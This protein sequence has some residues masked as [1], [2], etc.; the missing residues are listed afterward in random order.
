L[1]SIV[2]PS[3]PTGAF[4][5]TGY[6]AAD[7]GVE[8]LLTYFN[9]RVPRPGK[10]GGTLIFSAKHWSSSQCFIIQRPP[11]GISVGGTLS[12]AIGSIVS[13]VITLCVAVIPGLPGGV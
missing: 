9:M 3:T 4:F 10:S 12:T 6:A 5:S 13:A 7:Q 11:C 2:R 8:Q 1:R